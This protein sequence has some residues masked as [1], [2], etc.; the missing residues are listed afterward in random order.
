MP[1]QTQTSRID[2]RAPARAR[3]RGEAKPPQ[4]V[5]R[6]L[7]AARTKLKAALAEDTSTAMRA[8]ADLEYKIDYL[9]GQRAVLLREKTIRI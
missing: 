2:G 8:I 4:R 9:E 5:E 6:D 3:S 7:T 1:L